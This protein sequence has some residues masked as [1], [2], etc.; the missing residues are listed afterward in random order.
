MLSARPRVLGGGQP[1][2]AAANGAA[3]LPHTPARSI[4]TVALPVMGAGFF[5]L[6]RVEIAL[7]LKGNARLW[8]LGYGVLAI[9]CSVL[10]PRDRALPV[11]PLLWMWPLLVWSKLGMR[12]RYFDVAPVLFACARP[13]RRLLVAAW[14]A[15]FVLAAAPAAVLVLRLALAGDLASAGAVL[16]GAAFI[17]SLALAAGVWSGGSKLFEVLYL[18]LCYGLLNKAVAL[19]F[20][21]ATHEG[22]RTGMPILFA[23]LTAGPPDARDVGSRPPDPRLN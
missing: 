14:A 15:G 7:L 12:E 8:T 19:D 16:A 18:V 4:T 20:A 2:P 10:P 22:V 9:L 13:V 1:A 11:L 23:A 3:A 17:P 5:T 21:G 6:L